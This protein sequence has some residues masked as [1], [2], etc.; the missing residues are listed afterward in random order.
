MALSTGTWTER[1]KTSTTTTSTKL[2]RKLKASTRP[3]SKASTWARSRKYLWARTNSQKLNWTPPTMRTPCTWRDSCTNRTTP[4]SRPLLKERISSAITILTE[5]CPSPLGTTG[6]WL[7][8]IRCVCSES[9]VYRESNEYL[10]T[11]F[12]QVSQPHRRQGLG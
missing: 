4:C 12:D 9:T 11:R 1:S 3:T 10:P 7:S 6:I 2:P 8:L 5:N